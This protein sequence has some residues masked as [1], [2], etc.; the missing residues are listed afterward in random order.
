M[1]RFSSVSMSYLD[2]ASIGYIKLHVHAKSVSFNVICRCKYSNYLYGSNTV[3]KL[4]VFKSC[5]SFKV[6]N[7]NSIFGTEL[8]DFHHPI[9]S[10]ATTTIHTIN[11]F[12]SLQLYFT[13]L[14]YF[15]RCSQNHPFNPYQLL[16][17]LT[18]QFFNSLLLHTDIPT[19]LPISVNCSSKNHTEWESIVRTDTVLTFPDFSEG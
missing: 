2:T 7:N 6:K 9:C 17:T 1:S 18:Q 5:S 13:S 14:F 10:T 15:P 8:V 4:W 11:H 16:S 12:F 3:I 19:V